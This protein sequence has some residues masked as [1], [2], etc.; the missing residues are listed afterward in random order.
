GDG[1]LR[2][3]GHVNDDPVALDEPA[4]GKHAGEAGDLVVQLSIGEAQFGFGYRTIVDERE[5]IA[6]PRGDVAV[7]AIVAGVELPAG[8]PPIERR[9][10]AVEHFFPGFDPVNSPCGFGP[11]SLRI[12]ERPAVDII[13]ATHG[14]SV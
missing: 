1:G 5:A 9:V 11:E 14:P 13:D 6:I 7:E 2:H 4:S 8:E 3:H 10:G 12:V